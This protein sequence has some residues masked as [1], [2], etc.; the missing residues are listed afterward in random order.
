MATRTFNNYIAYV[1]RCFVY[2]SVQYCQGLQ[3]GVDDTML[4][5]QVMALHIYLYTMVGDSYDSYLTNDEVEN[6]SKGINAI[7]KNPHLW[8]QG[9]T[10]TN[11]ST[12][13]S[14][15]I[16]GGG[17]TGTITTGYG[18]HRQE[19]IATAGQTQFTITLWVLGDVYMC[20]IDDMPQDPSLFTRVGNVITAA[21]PLTE[22]QTLIVY[23]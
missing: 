2:K 12:A 6:I 15:N 5:N 8:I 22:N 3:M 19:F 4:L 14:W 18:L 21:V 13:G 9:I 10:T 23:G 11:I 17:G 16:T 20:L 1:A 7:C